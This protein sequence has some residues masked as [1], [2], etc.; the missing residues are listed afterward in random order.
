[1]SSATSV[2]RTVGAV[3]L[4]G[5]ALLPG[6]GAIC[7]SKFLEYLVSEGYR[8]ALTMV[9]NFYLVDACVVSDTDLHFSP[10]RGKFGGI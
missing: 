8:Y 7:L 2:R 10:V 5:A 6:V 1:M 3:A 4:A 9:F